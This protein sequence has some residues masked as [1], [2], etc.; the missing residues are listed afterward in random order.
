MSKLSGTPPSLS[1]PR[2]LMQLR[3]T[4]VVNQS[5]GLALV[6]TEKHTESW[7]QAG[8]SITMDLFQRGHGRVTIDLVMMLRHLRATKSVPHHHQNTHPR[9]SGCCP[10]HPLLS[11]N[12][13]YS[14][15][16]SLAAPPFQ[17]V[18][19]AANHVGH[20]SCVGAA[21]VSSSAFV[22]TDI[23][24][25]EIF[26]SAS[27]SGR[28]PWAKHITSFYRHFFKF[29]NCRKIRLRPRVDNERD[30]IRRP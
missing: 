19:V 10:P 9:A 14:V 30:S 22:S 15:P 25:S 12:P 6:H 29:R 24:N 4:T 7:N 16:P 23:D 17:F 11:W 2:R 20:S 1:L 3:Y 21:S 13:A 28:C 27:S 26:N 8:G 5:L 18:G